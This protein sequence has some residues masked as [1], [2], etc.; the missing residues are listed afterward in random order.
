MIRVDKSLP[1]LSF[2]LAKQSLLPHPLLIRE[3]LQSLNPFVAFSWTPSPVCVSHW[4]LGCPE[5]GT[6]P[7][8]SRGKDHLCHPAAAARAIGLVCG[9]LLAPVQLQDPR[10]FSAKGFSS[11]VAPGYI[12]VW[13]CS[14]TAHFSSLQRS[15]WMAAGPTGVSAWFCV[16][17]SLAEGMLSPSSLTRIF[18]ESVRGLAEGS[19][20]SACCSPLSSWQSFHCT[21]LLKS[22]FP[23]LNPC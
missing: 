23:L 4:A 12:S 8:G 15:L 22:D 9:T 17:C 7:V 2:L 20:G 6:A 16:T 21:G 3:V 18:W 5:L 10:A 14:S 13:D 1:E 19:V 11:W